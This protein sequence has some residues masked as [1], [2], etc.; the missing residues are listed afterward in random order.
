MLH[1]RRVVVRHKVNTAGWEPLSDVIN[2]PDPPSKA[3]HT[4]Y[5]PHTLEP[6]QFVGTPVS[7]DHQLVSAVSSG[8]RE[9]GSYLST[10]SWDLLVL[11]TLSAFASSGHWVMSRVIVAVDSPWSEPSNCSNAAQSPSLTSRA[12]TAAATPPP[13]P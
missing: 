1:R 9:G 12:D 10:R 2:S 6:R 4:A 8:A 5:R 11:V 3:V 7:Q 13:H